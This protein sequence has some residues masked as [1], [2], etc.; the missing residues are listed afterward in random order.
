MN[1]IGFLHFLF[2]LL[3]AAESTGVIR[4]GFF[5]VWV[6]IEPS[7]VGQRRWTEE[8]DGRQKRRHDEDKNRKR[9]G[10]KS[11]SAALSNEIQ[12][13]MGETTERCCGSL[14]THQ[15]PK[16]ERA[17]VCLPVHVNSCI[18]QLA[19][20]LCT[21]WV[22][23]WQK[24]ELTLFSR[25]GD[26]CLPPC[27]CA[28]VFLRAR[29]WELN[30]KIWALLGQSLWKLTL[31]VKSVMLPTATI[32]RGITAHNLGGWGEV[33]VRTIRQI[34]SSCVQFYPQFLGRF[35]PFRHCLTCLADACQ[36]LK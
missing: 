13:N 35:E 19:C 22:S 31:A 26:G 7:K 1:I 14:R 21:C 34:A 20:E 2:S 15:R 36:R 23:V 24:E 17:F 25:L 33:G 9:A 32:L 6:S 3:S 5:F 4:F 11:M 18:C 28:D 16:G 27:F 29:L 30:N 8:E 10:E 12:V